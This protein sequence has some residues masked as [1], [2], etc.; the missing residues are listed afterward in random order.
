MVV[1]LVGIFIRRHCVLTL[2][3]DAMGWSV[4]VKSDFNHVGHIKNMC[5]SGYTLQNN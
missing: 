4:I 3:Q 5:G 1:Y 2:P